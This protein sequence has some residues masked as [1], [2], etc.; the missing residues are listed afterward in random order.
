MAALQISKAASPNPISSNLYS[1][2]GDHLGR[3]NFAPQCLHKFQIQNTH[4]INIFASFP[5]SL[6]SLFALVLMHNLLF[7]ALVAAFAT[8]T[9]ESLCWNTY[10]ILKQSTF[11]SRLE[12]SRT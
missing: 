3:K 2:S 12:D 6:L 9:T 7:I 5:T 8:S 11:W 4:P 10:A 1:P